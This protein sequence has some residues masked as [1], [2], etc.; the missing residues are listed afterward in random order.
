MEGTLWLGNTG[1][2]SN[3][4][5]QKRGGNCDSGGRIRRIED[6]CFPPLQRDLWLAQSDPSGVERT[7][8]LIARKSPPSL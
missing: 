3:A 6:A 8:R 1:A 2:S 7:V 5:G 4:R